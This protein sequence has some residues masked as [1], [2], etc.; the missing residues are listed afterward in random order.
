MSIDRY[1][2]AT[3]DKN[4][5]TDIQQLEQELGVV[6]VAVAP[7]PA[8]AQLADDALQRLQAMEQQTGKVLLAY[9]Q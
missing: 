2:T 5:L 6:L 3:L 1:H 4:T 8:P 9:S 7:F